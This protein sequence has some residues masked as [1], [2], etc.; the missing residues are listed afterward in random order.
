MNTI[1]RHLAFLA[2]QSTDEEK[3]SSDYTLV[4]LLPYAVHG[5]QLMFLQIKAGLVIMVRGTVILW[6]FCCFFS[7]FLYTLICKLSHVVEAY[8]CNCASCSYHANVNIVT[9]QRPPLGIC[10][11]QGLAYCQRYVRGLLVVRDDSE[12]QYRRVRI[13][14]R[15]ILVTKSVLVKPLL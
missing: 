8:L 12:N 13:N 7:S 11:I 15:R 1:A 10:Q 4:L 9:R 5:T 3:F 2:G 6:Y 14:Q